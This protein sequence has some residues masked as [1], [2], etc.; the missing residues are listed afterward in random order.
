MVGATHTAN[1]ERT[2][3]ETIR[4]LTRWAAQIRRDDKATRHPTANEEA[5]LLE[6][7]AELLE[8]LKE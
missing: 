6:H 7:A 8:R 5:A 4:A 3:D 1:N 2:L